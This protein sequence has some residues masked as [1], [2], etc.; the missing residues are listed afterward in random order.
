MNETLF[1]E[2]RDILM[3]KL[4][5]RH[6][7]T[8][9]LLSVTPEEIAEALLIR[10]KALKDQLPNIVKNLDNEAEALTPKLN[11]I[12]EKNEKIKKKISEIKKQRDAHQK[13]AGEIWKKI[14]DIQ[15]ELTESGNMINL[16]PKWKKERMIEELEE[17]EFNIQ[18]VA[19]DHKAEKKM[20]DARRNIIRQNELWLKERKSSNP[21]MAEF[22]EKRKK[23]N[24]LYKAADKEHKEMIKNVN[25]GEPV[26][27]KYMARKM[28]LVDI[29]RQR[30]RARQLLKNLDRDISYWENTI[31][32]GFDELM[33]LALKVQKGGE[34][35]FSSNKNK[36]EK[37]DINRKKMEEEE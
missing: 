8:E 19:L 6:V 16:D 36:K 4:S 1:E 18:T 13:E 3:M 7:D 24:S 12:K 15:N 22:I 10:R 17:I 9:T 25:L 28:E 33:T 29:E 11:K 32:E 27:A 31:L 34:S 35:S 5:G 2:D 26:H 14:K 21:Q 20:I 37:N 30:D 23:M